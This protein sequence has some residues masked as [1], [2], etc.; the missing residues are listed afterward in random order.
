MPAYRKASIRELSLSAY[1][2]GGRVFQG[3][4]RRTD[5]GWRVGNMSL[6]QFLERAQGR[7]VAVL[8]FDMEED[9]PMEKKVCRTCGREYIGSTCP[10]CRET[11]L[12]L[13][14]R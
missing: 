9:V 11:R 4:L 7:E 5:D 12:R 3:I 2:L 6:E 1:E 13:R 8:V 14:G 10:Y